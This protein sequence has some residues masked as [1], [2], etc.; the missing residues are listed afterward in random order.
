MLLC[1]CSTYVSCYSYLQIL[2]AVVNCDKFVQQVQ[3]NLELSEKERS[4]RAN[5]VLPFEHQGKFCEVK[6][7]LSSI[8][9]RFHFDS[10][11]CIASGT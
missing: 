6:L 10:R 11:R 5:V 1:L 3:F 8:S 9:L 4:D 7:F 2:V